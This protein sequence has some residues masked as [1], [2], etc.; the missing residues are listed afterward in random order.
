MGLEQDRITIARLCGTARRLAAA[1]TPIDQA[2]T[3]LHAI[4]RDPRL[5]GQASGSELGGWQADPIRTCWGQRISRLLDAAGAD[6]A[7][8]D[9]WAAWARGE[10]LAPPAESR[11]G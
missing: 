1:R 4:T 10:R 6:P 7:V 2:V 11:R 5:L 8:R 3:E 9:E